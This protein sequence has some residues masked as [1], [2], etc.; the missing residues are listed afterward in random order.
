MLKKLFSASVLSLFLVAPGFADQLSVTVEVPVAK[1][2]EAIAAK[3]AAL[4]NA[5]EKVCS[6]VKYTGLLSFYEASARQD[7]IRQTYAKALKD[8]DS[9][10]M[11]ASNTYDEPKLD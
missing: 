4:L 1:T 3:E 8:A 7:C 6:Q 2:S 10:A 11:L 5:A 9:A